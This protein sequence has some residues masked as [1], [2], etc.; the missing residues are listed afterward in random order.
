MPL[1]TITSTS[2]RL[3]I[4]MPTTLAS[5]TSPFEEQL[6]NSFTELRKS[7]N[8]L[9]SAC[10]SKPTQPQ[11]MARR[12]GVNRNLSWK[13]SKVLCAHDLYEAIQHLP[14]DE[15][16]EIMIRAAEKKGV[17]GPL[18]QSVR[19]ALAAFNQVVEV[20]SGDRATLDLML[21]S[22]GGRG[23]S[24]RLEQSRKLAFRGNCG[25]W[26]AQVRVRASTLIVAPNMDN[27]DMLD[28][29]LVGGIVDFRRLRPNLRW[30]LFR[31]RMYH[32][33]YNPMVH[34][35]GDEA[36]DP[37]FADSHGPKLIST[38]CSPN[39]PAINLVSEAGGS[40]YELSDGPV[41]NTGSFTCFFGTVSRAVA[42]RYASPGDEHGELDTQILLPLEWL[43]V[44]MLL[45]REFEITSD[46]QT[47]M[48]GH[49]GSHEPGA[50]ALRIPFDEPP[51]E[52]TGHPPMLASSLVDR[53]DDLMAWV[54][55]RL[56]RSA[57]DF[58]AYRL[59][60][61]YPPMHSNVVVRF[62]LPKR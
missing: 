34:G 9:V 61:R 52:L 23:N 21:D 28:L 5:K 55:G 46:F 54:F 11:E 22:W 41:G 27:P 26:G 56:G 24:E 4:A 30:P 45:H 31:P 62:P 35:P 1:R 37:A 3:L 8:S 15:G 58:R 59:L 13:F 40:A 60:V 20:H 38:F 53:Y 32:D 49:L 10:G 29:S 2:V 17:D 47:M 33:N 48:F 44:D 50:S 14:G 42:N 51:T 39:M 16:V 36:L 12:L 18:A 7:L 43:Q 57:R 19:S 6:T 25:V